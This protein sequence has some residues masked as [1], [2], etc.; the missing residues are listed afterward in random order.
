[1]SLT[2]NQQID[3]AMSFRSSPIGFEDTLRRNEASEIQLAT[4]L[5]NRLG[6]SL[7]VDFPDIDLGIS[8][9]KIYADGEDDCS[10]MS[11]VILQNVELPTSIR[12]QLSD[13]SDETC[14]HLRKSVP[15]AFIQ[16]CLKLSHGATFP[17][18][19]HNQSKWYFR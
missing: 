3:L 6:K 14:R 5:I 13:L 7:L 4:D 9:T 10:P 19:Q 17:I 2:I 18:V 1:M 11:D 8:I 16:I 12:T 15:Q